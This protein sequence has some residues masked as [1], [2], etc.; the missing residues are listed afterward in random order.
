MKR[1]KKYKNSIKNYDT[2]E[3]FNLKDGIEEVKKLSYSKFN[4][5][6]EVHA[7]IIVPK[8]RDPK[9]IKG[10]YTL[11]H[12][13][14][15]NDV[16]IA[17]FCTPELEKDAKEAGADI[18]GLDKLT[19]DVKAGKIEFDIA[20]ASPSVMPKIAVLGRELGPKGLMPNPKN[21][22]VTDDFTSAIKEYKQGK[23]TFAC[24]ESGVIHLNAGKL[25]MSTEELIENVEACIKAIEDTL[26]KN[27][28]Q[29]I[30]KLHLAPT[31]GASV[32]IGYNE[33]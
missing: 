23:M 21:G 32:K 25:D 2:K 8:D 28:A 26:G 18:V 12:S 31:M 5:T 16:K 22:T 14:G 20:I 10:A 13:T 11:P 7:D 4:G 6:L 30:K 3:V 29:A 15:N 9:S 1:G 17:V 33:E 19:K 24:D 27:Y